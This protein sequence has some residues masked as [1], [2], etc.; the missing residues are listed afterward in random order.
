MSKAIGLIFQGIPISQC[1]CG[2]VKHQL[3]SA[4]QSVAYYNHG[5]EALKLGSLKDDL[6]QL[7]LTPR[8]I[9]LSHQFLTFKSYIL[10]GYV[11]S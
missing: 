8:I 9:R 6:S 4:K 10:F 5:I 3:N 2:T 7:N 1:T 11:W